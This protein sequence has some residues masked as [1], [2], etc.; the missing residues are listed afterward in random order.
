MARSAQIAVF[1]LE[2][3][4]DEIGVRLLASEARIDGGRLVRGSSHDLELQRLAVSLDAVSAL[5]LYVD[6][7]ST[8]TLFEIRA[9]SR[10]LKMSS[11]LDGVIVDYVQLMEGDHDLDN[12]NLQ[13][14]A[15]TRGL[16]VMAKDLNV[17][18]I[19]L[20][21]LNR[22]AAK[23]QNKEPELEDLRDTGAL[24][25][26]ADVVIMI[27]RKDEEDET[28]SLFVRK[29]RNGPKG[30]VVVNWDDAQTRFS[31]IEGP[32]ML[33]GALRSALNK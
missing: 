12:R 23:R 4:R 28:A 30:K 14:A 24:E 25:Q 7:A 9:K 29:Q 16:K 2:M 18:V 10:A 8:Q 11:G 5:H 22:G 20:S 31:D 6:D 21:Q 17:P 15:I 26:D 33:A 3:S 1:S 32:G 27:H 19:C 13:L